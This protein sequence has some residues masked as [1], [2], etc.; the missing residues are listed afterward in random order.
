MGG[1]LVRLSKGV[2]IE[3]EGK[4]SVVS[5]AGPPLRPGGTFDWWLTPGY[6]ATS[7]IPLEADDI[8]L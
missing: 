5:Q 4:E 3:E 7:V 2:R 8:P 1:G 6:M